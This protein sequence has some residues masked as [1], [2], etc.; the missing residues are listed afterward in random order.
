MLDETCGGGDGIAWHWS[1]VTSSATN[2]QLA[3]VLASVLFTGIVLLF[4]RRERVHLQI[5][6]LFAAG[7]MSLGLDSYMFSMITGIRPLVQGKGI[8]ESACLQAWAQGM[9][10]SGLLA[11][12]GTS[13]VCGLGWMLSTHQT[14]AAQKQESGTLRPVDNYASY[15]TGWMSAGVILTTTLLL[16]VTN[17]DFL[18]VMYALKPS[19]FLHRAVLSLDIAIALSSSG[20]A[21][22]RT[23]RPR[24]RPGNPHES[25]PPRTLPWAAYSIV[26]SAA[27]GT[28]F[29][30]LL[31]HYPENWTSAWIYAI[32]VFGILFGSIAPCGISILLAMSLPRLE[33]SAPAAPLQPAAAVPP[34]PVS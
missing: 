22:V 3:G 34:E 2:S 24:R 27:C 33:G 31:T 18:D 13:L 26:I 29:A 28:I 7:F 14:E 5:I 10:A 30:G 16:A 19:P 9:P 15:L 20:I 17:W 23:C 25:A 12:G 6:A 1:I 21:L 4:G 8:S 11:V 32:S